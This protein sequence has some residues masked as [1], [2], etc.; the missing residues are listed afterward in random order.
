MAKQLRLWAK[1]GDV[2]VQYVTPLGW[3]PEG[4]T[5]LRVVYATLEELVDAG[6]IRLV[7]ITPDPVISRKFL[8]EVLAPESKREN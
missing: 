8:Y 3:Q 6:K 2:V 5:E 7:S 4:P 1:E